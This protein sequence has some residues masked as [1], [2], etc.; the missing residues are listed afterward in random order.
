MVT[1]L[2]ELPPWLPANSLC[3]LVQRKQQQEYAIAASLTGPQIPL[4]PGT[5]SEFVHTFQACAQ[6]TPI[7]RPSGESPQSLGP[8]LLLERES[9]QF[10]VHNNSTQGSKKEK[11][12][13][14]QRCLL[15]AVGSALLSQAALASSVMPP[16]TTNTG[17]IHPRH[18]RGKR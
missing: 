1:Y 15:N 3:L 10:T 14:E 2:T 18:E 16:P 9:P 7:P 5:T 13:G 11:V 12:T 4:F 17:H 6:T 8:R